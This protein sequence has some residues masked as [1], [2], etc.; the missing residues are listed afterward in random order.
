MSNSHHQQPP[1]EA[2]QDALD[3]ALCLSNDNDRLP[4]QKALDFLA[5]LAAAA[6]RAPAED[7]KSRDWLLPSKVESYV[8]HREQW[9]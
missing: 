2:R 4:E 6:E 7:R 8:L 5:E 9:I 1:S 3:L